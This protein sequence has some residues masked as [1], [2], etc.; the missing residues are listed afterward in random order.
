[1]NVFFTD[2]CISEFKAT[3]DYVRQ[4]PLFTA[5]ETNTL[6][7]DP[8]KWRP[9]NKMG[10]NADSLIYKPQSNQTIQAIN[11]TDSE[12][13]IDEAHEWFPTVFSHVK[14]WIKDYFQ[15]TQKHVIYE[16]LIIVI[17]IILFV[18]YKISKKEKELPR[19]KKRRRINKKCKKR[20]RSRSETTDCS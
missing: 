13:N 10:T 19:R 6:V 14:I 4:K 1:M 16:I 2:Y 20:T 9:T 18:A 17:A 8:S 5:P 7:V 3:C 12:A 11:S 15:Q